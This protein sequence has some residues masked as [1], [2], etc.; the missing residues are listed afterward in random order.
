MRRKLI[1][2]LVLVVPMWLMVP[3]TNHIHTQRQAMKYGG[4]NVSRKMRLEIGQGMAIALLAGFRGVVA[5]FLWIQSHGYWEK[6]QW[7]RQY[8]K[9]KQVVTLQPQSTVF[10]DS[11]AWHMAWNI[12]YATSVDTN[13]YTQAQ[14]TRRQHEWWERA[15]D[16]LKTGI[17]NIPNKYDLYFSLAWLYDQKFKDYCRAEEYF[18]KAATF[19]TAP[20]YVARMQARAKEK[21]G[22][23]RGAYA[24][25]LDLW[26]QDHTKV[27]QQ[28]S[29]VGREI[30][31]LE[32]LMNMPNDKRVFAKPATP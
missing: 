31:R 28:W 7:L 29:I 2:V 12:G 6:K 15:E 22:D 30:R 20:S 18:G 3:L 13:V 17:E 10:W 25:W 19:K 24:Y 1:A 16:Y 9:M 23:L 5:D 11:G 21:C 14:A 4:A 32:D 27:D 26:T 8:Q